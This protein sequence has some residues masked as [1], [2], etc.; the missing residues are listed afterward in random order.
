MSY[1]KTCAMLRQGD[2]RGS[3]RVRPVRR[4]LLLTVMMMGSSAMSL[5]AAA[6][7]AAATRTLGTSVMLTASLTTR[8]GDYLAALSRTYAGGDVKVTLLKK[9]GSIY[10]STW[11]MDTEQTMDQSPPSLSLVD[12]NKDGSPEVYWNHVSYGVSVG[13]HYFTLY[14]SARKRLYSSAI[15]EFYGG[16]RGDSIVEYAPAL[17]E[18][19]NA[20]FLS[21]IVGKV[22]KDDA[23][24]QANAKDP[25]GDM[26]RAWT[27][28]YGVIN[29]GRVNF[30]AIKPVPASTTSLCNKDPGFETARLTA[31][32]LTYVARHKDGVYVLDP[33]KKTCALI[34]FPEDVYQWVD[35]LKVVE[36][37]IAMRNRTTGKYLYFDPK[38]MVLGTQIAR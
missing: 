34:Y 22:E 25:Y 38:D 7:K 27:G 2:A 16:R 32:G 18:P 36:G 24:P 15:T 21:F 29:S 31:G 13:G 9:V 5:S 1:I 30:V 10:V 20:T 26:I 6:A 28:K 17:L 19:A 4:F 23:F 35:Q 3:C 37:W 14:D 11:S 33:K 8:T 12:L